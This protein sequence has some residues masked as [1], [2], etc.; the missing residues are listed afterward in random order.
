MAAASVSGCFFFSSHPAASS[1]ST[2]KSS[3]STTHSALSFP[4]SS[5]I[6]H[7][8]NCTSSRIYAK[9]EKFQVDPAQENTEATNRKQA[10][11]QPPQS[12]QEDQ[13]EEEDD[14]FILLL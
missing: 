7:G 10:E 6:S 12:V 11:G 5:G 3:T 1:S 4:P 9:F 8:I 14:R 13:K 2:T